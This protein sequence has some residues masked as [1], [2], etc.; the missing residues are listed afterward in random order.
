[1]KYIL[2]IFEWKIIWN[3]LNRR[4]TLITIICQFFGSTGN[5][6]ISESIVLLIAALLK[7]PWILSVLKSSAFII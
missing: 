1:M 7:G 5:C 2:N 6:S 4:H 3:V